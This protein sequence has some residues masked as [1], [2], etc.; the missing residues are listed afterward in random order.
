[1]RCVLADPHGSALYNWAKTGELAS[2][3]NSITE[4]IGN[5]RITANMEGVPIDDAIQI[6]DPEALRTIYQLLYQEGLF[7]GGSV[8]INVAAAVKLAQQLG[9][10]HKIVTVLCDGG[11][12]Y[13]SRI[14]SRPWLEAKG[15]WSEDLAPTISGG[16][17]SQIA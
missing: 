1:V 12:R 9:P 3:G 11:S 7:M 2:E 17:A 16:I 4:G 14:Y 10:G 5:S 8:G 13:Q 6:D 15:L